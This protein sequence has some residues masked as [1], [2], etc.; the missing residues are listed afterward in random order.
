MR[1]TCFT[2]SPNSTLRLLA[3][4]QL[5]RLV[6]MALLMLSLPLSAATVTWDGGS[7]GPGDDN[8]TTAANWVGDVAPVAGDDLVFAGTTRLTPTNNFTADTSFGSITFNNTSGAFVLGGNRITLTGVITNND[9][10]GQTIN[11]AMVM[12]ATRTFNSASGTISVTGVL[13]GAGGMTKSGTG[14]L[15]LASATNTYAGGTTISAGTVQLG[16][17]SVGTENAAALGSGT[18]TINSGGTLFFNPGSTA[19]T[20]NFTNSFL[21]NGG[22]IICGDGNQRLAT[23]GASFTV[24]ASGGSLQ[25]AW[26]GKDIYIDGVM[27]G[28]GALAISPYGNTGSGS[29]VLVTNGANTY[30]GTITLTP[31]AATNISL[32]ISQP[33][34]LQYASITLAA[35]G[36][37]SNM[38]TVSENVTT[39]VAGL[40]G[41]AG[42]V[43][44]GPTAGAYLLA[45]NAAANST[46][47]GILIDGTG[48][49]LSLTKSGTGS[50]SQSGANTYTGVTTLTGGTLSVATIGNGGVAGNLGQ[51]T[52]AA[53]NV[54]FNGGTLQY[55]G[56]TASTDRNF[57]IN[58]ATTGTIDIT[59][60]TLTISGAD[61]ATTGALRKIGTGT[62]I[63]S[64]ANL[65]TGA[66]TVNAGTLLVNS[67]GSL[68]SG[69]TLT[70]ANLATL[71]GTGTVAGTVALSAGGIL[72]PGTGGTTTGTLSTGAVTMNATSTYSID[73]NSTTPAND[74]VTSTGAVVCAGTLTIASFVGSTART[75]TIASGSSVTGTFSGLAQGASIVAGRRTFSI[76]YLSNQVTLTDAGASTTVT[77]DGGGANDL[78]STAEN[79]VGDVAPVAGDRLVFAGTTRLTPTNDFTAGTNF[80]SITF[81]SGAG[82]F[83]IGGNA[84]TLNG[85]ATVITNS[86]TTGTMTLALPLTFATAAPTIT[87]TAGSVLNTS[88][89]GTIDNGALLLTVTNAGVPMTFTG[90][91]SN[92]GGLTKNGSGTLVLAGVNSYTGATTV[93]A[94]SLRVT[95]STAVSSAVTVNS[96]GTVSGTGTVAGTVA[97]ANGGTLSPGI[98]SQLVA[99]FV[100]TSL[101]AVTQDDWRATQTIR[102]I[103]SDLTINQP[104]NAFGTAAERAAYGIGGS[105]TGW[106]N[107]SVQWDG[108][109][110]VP[111]GATT[112]STRSDD[113]SRV[114][115]DLNNNGVID[116]GEWGSNGWGS[117]QGETTRTVRANLAA[118]TYRMRVQYE[119]GNGGNAMYLLWNDAVN[120]AGTVAG[121][122]VVPAHLLTPAIGT[123]TTGAVT[124][125]SASTFQVDLNGTTPTFDRLSTAGAVACAGTLTIGSVVNP[126]VGKVYTIINAGA[127]SG[128]FSG[129]ANNAMFVQQ[130]RTYQIA[131]TGTTVTLTDVVRPTTRI[132][133]GGGGDN[134]WTTAANWDYDLVPVTGDD[135]QFAG[136]ARLAPN[137]DIAADTSFGSITFSSGAGAFVL[138]G[139]RITLT[140]AITNNDDSTQTINL[141]MVIAAT[142]TISCTS[143]AITV[144]GIISGGGGGLTKIGGSILTLSG[145]NTYTGST[146]VTAGTLAFPT[147]GNLDATGAII[148]NGGKLLHLGTAILPNAFS[149]TASSTIES[150][151]GDDLTLTGNTI[152][153]T[154]GTVLSLVTTGGSSG[155]IHTLMF[156]GSGFTFAGN[157][158]SDTWSRTKFD[159]ASGTQTFSGVFSGTPGV[160]SQIIWRAAAGGSTVLSGANTYSGNTLIDRGTLQL[161]AADV[162][163]DGSA[164]SLTY[165]DC[166][167]DLNDFSE[168]IGSLSG[169]G[170]VLLGSATLTTGGDNSSTTYSGAMSETGSLTKTGAG[171]FILSGINTYTGSTQIAAGILSVTG[172]TAAG[173]A[174]TVSSGGT[175]TGT[176][177]VA[178][179]VAVANGGTLAPGVGVGLTASFVA[180]SL[181]AVTQDDWRSTQ[182]I[183]GTRSDATIDQPTSA[184]GTGVE[185]AAFVIG[186]SDADW[187]NFSVQW[188]GYLRVNTAGTTLFTRSDDGSRV[189]LDLNGNGVVDS[190]EWGSNGWG[191]GQGETTRI[192]HAGLAAGTYRMRVQYDEGNGGNAMYLMWDDATNSAGVVDGKYVVPSLL[193]KGGSSIATLTTG[194]VTLN[195]TSSYVVDL[196][197]TTPT[198]DQVNSTGAVA[199]AGTLTIDSMANAGLGKVYTI[200]NAGSVSGTFSGLANATLFT[201]QGRVFQIAYTATTVTLTDVARPTTRVW[202]GG[203]GDNNW[204]TAANWDYE[205]APIAGDDLQFAGTTRLTPNN[206]YPPETAFAS[207]TFTSGAGAFVI[208]PTASSTGVISREVWTGIGTNDISSIPL[209]TTANINDT[210]SSME[211]PTDWADS[212]G[213]RLRG[214]ITAPTTGNY[215]FWVASD[216]NGELRL[217]TDTLV[218]NKVLIASVTGFTASREWGKFGSQ[219]SAEIALVAG[220]KYYIEVL[221]KEGGGGDNLAVGWAKPGE[222]TTAP[223]EVVPSAYLT[224]YSSNYGIELA[225]GITNNS[226]NLQTVNLGLYLGATRSVNCTSGNIALGGIISGSGGLIKTGASVLTLTGTNTFTGTTT[227][228]AGTLQIGNGTTDGSIAT[229]AGITDNAALVYNLVGSRTYGNVI[230]GTGTLSKSGAGTLTLS[231]ANTYT[232]ATTVS[233]GT[234]LV[235]GSTAS[236][237]AVGVANAATLGGTGTVAGT[238]TLN[239]GGILAPGTGGTT[240]GTLATGAVTCSATSVYAVDLNGTGPTADRTSSTGAVALAGTL[241]V[242]SIGNADYLKTYTI[243]SGSSISGTFA[244][245]PN[246]TLFTQQGRN[247]LITYNATT[248]TLTD[249]DPTY[250]WVWDGGGAD[251]NWTTA[252][253]WVN[254]VQPG[255]GA[256]L[257]FAGSTRLTPNNDFPADTSFASITFNSGGGAFV[258]GGNRITLAGAVTNNDDSVQTMNQALIMAATR[259]MDAASGDLVLGGILS[260]AGGLSKTGTGRLTLT[261]TN[262]YTGVTTISV[263]TLSV[264]DGTTD[265]SIATSSGITNNSALL[266]NLAGARSYGNVISGTGTLTKAGAGT[267]TLSATNT[268]SGATT[269]TGGILSVSANANLGTAPGVATPGAITLNGGTLRFTGATAITLNANRGIALGNSGGTIAITI[270]VGSFAGTGDPGVHYSGIIAD[271]GGQSGALTVSGVGMLMLYGSSTYSGTTTIDTGWISGPS[272]GGPNN[273]ILPTTTILNVINGGRFNLCTSNVTQTIAG[274]T[275]DGTGLVG[276]TNQSSP[277]TLIINNTGNHTFPGIL[278]PLVHPAKTGTATRFGL[279]KTGS[280]TQTLSGINTYTAATTV[281]AGTLLVTGSTATGSAVAVNSTATLGG[282]GTVGGTIAL[283]AGGTLAPGTGGTTI[284]TLATGAVTCNATATYSVNL[285]GTGPTADLMSSTGAVALAGTLTVASITNADY[286]K[287]Y[288][289]VSGSSITGT[290]TGLPNHTIFTQQGRNFLIRYTSTAVTLTDADP[291]YVWV[292]DGGGA[293]DNWTTAANWVNDVA[294]GIG[295]ALQFA[296][297]TRLTPSNDFPADTSFASI[298]F[299]SGAGAFIM[300]GN[301]LTLT[302]NITNNDDSVQAMNQAMIIAAT[303]TMNA[304][305]GNF[306]FGGILSGAGGL[307][308]SGAGTV[309]LVATN[310]FTGAITISAGALSVGDGVTNGSIATSS[311]ITNS[312]ALVYNLVGSNTYANVISGTGTLTKSGPGTL[313]LTGINTYTGATTVSAG[314]LLVTGSTASG[315]TMEVSSGATLG[316]SGT[317]AGA[318]TVANGGTLAP[319]TGGTTIAT[320]TTGAVTLSVSSTYTVDLNGTIPTFDQVS[321]SGTVACAGTL[322]IAS[323]SNAALGKV[324]TIV[325]AASVT[326]TFS[327]LA[328]NAVFVHAGRLFRITYSATTVILTD[329]APVVISR[330]TL[331]VDGDG[332]IDRV[333][334]TFDQNLNDNTSGLTVAVAGYTVASFD[335]GTANDNVIDVV[336]TESGAGDTGATPAVRITVNSSLMDAAGTMLIQV[337]GSGTAATDA[338]APVL[339]SSAWTDGDANGVDAGDTIT[340][341]FSESVIVSGMVVADLGLPVTGDSL[342]SSTIANQAAATLTVTL[343]GTPLLTPGGIYGSGALTSGKPSGIYVANPLVIADAVGLNPATG[344]AASARDI[345]GSDLLAIAWVTGSDPKVWALGTVVLGSTANTTAAVDLALR[346]VGDS[347]ANL[348][349]AVVVSAPSGWAPAAAAGTDQF[350]LKVDNAGLPAADPT[351]PA[352]YELTLSTVGQPLINGL[353]SGLSTDFEFYLR[354]PTAITVGA[355]IQQTTTV[356]IT[357]A[358]P[359]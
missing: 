10:D 325:S 160:G 137:N 257:Q 237:S 70:V 197:G 314:T 66:T 41:S 126:A 16:T 14:S 181:R 355:G 347:T 111:T 145:T 299:N 118:G 198:F 81:N 29:G 357:A 19:T 316:G 31:A 295:A 283:N 138:G 45:V 58:S 99:S 36:G 158:T 204:T 46:Y 282:T 75:Y 174:V 264:G 203:G 351:N 155:A 47:S 235:T 105:D 339:L 274:L 249:L 288:T 186:G 211:T 82:A 175:L 35:G 55:T 30:S 280:G 101:R 106:D 27:A 90:V 93:N 232:G 169:V 320:L 356:T 291:A 86:A 123:L 125:N 194:A 341:T 238:I 293:D 151:D 301:R 44:G 213:T 64:G 315:S 210:L 276:T 212:Y 358:L 13:S 278:G 202:D 43:R 196:N 92:T 222:A 88:A 110:T 305:S 77:W 73:L 218:A 116:T 136:M 319:G 275:G 240:I 312:A 135:L 297:T 115:L 326:G 37:T 130:G 129:L 284:G 236:G 251:N 153:G 184:F 83:T 39:T 345:A 201:Q 141:A 60:N 28:S 24:G 230:S 290:F 233:A 327:G 3:T 142:R 335:V 163:P 152:S 18:V 59:T 268:Y 359:P 303:R 329:V 178:G 114:W 187:D 61:T 300:G 310:T 140:G 148:L 22:T 271:V 188:D 229:S 285:N 162:I 1:S 247:F 113:G 96:G 147:S 100:N 154:A 331:D 353:R 348:T 68:A 225:G 304:A 307:T 179:T 253:N 279:T 20:Y 167:L 323:L 117:G 336:L 56:A 308:K 69:S 354:T 281:N 352:A 191:N 7:T 95:G 122:Y 294:P 263:G 322:T 259:T 250:V 38:W 313:T 146:T 192:V 298:T 98:A 54:V 206:D 190:G 143:G 176:G 127:V 48:G 224:P 234:L 74:R 243:F 258:I 9:A 344:N 159:N 32:H 349:I 109:L 171:T 133:D 65:H 161:A 33:S 121:L 231:G 57:T 2:D 309:T 112:L 168:T 195:S 317:V 40:S 334:L 89:A 149:V 289:I 139:N 328:N 214:F 324:Y 52:N 165:A 91:I 53:A 11:L 49:T 164:V 132:W 221:Q 108:F 256:A 51:A 50:L 311:G 219:K 183:T 227:I 292:W 223:S 239:A 350:L 71:G 199:C 337:E 80:A 166:I 8:W 84:I 246:H 17:G 42:F 62:L 25:S 321:T 346:N 4:V 156:S 215:T 266:Y 338:A 330:Q 216:D 134:N 242:A 87:S 265:G 12:A 34:A 273:N 26:S 342:A 128:T 180:T 248:V 170:P 228:S 261:A 150:D 6:A 302:G 63:L 103:R 15:I 21:L 67:P 217:S 269:V 185:R 254:D 189:W 182:T 318:V 245:L 102:G 85:G 207:I 332:Q 255:I 79:W 209:S 226:S 252:A 177:T 287:T 144:G 306:V 107:F 104:G 286:L 267:L 78:W 76:S 200:I 241:T 296:G 173:S 193:L 343:A 131:Y 277:S 120:S 97:V 333:R 23:G 124:F 272:A 94:G 208:G 5:H 157:I 262:T 72:A 172:S 244:G 205:I 270:P 119:E 340:L 220:R 260:G